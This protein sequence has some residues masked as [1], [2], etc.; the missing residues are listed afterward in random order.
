MI[1]VSPRA[2]PGLHHVFAWAQF[3]SGRFCSRFPSA[4]ALFAGLLLPGDSAASGCFCLITFFQ[5]QGELAFGVMILS[6]C[7]GGITS[8][9]MTR[10]ARGDV[11][12]SISYTAIV[13]L[14]TALTLPLILSIALAPISLWQST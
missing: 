5:L 14:L 4:K 2:Q 8:N 9:V 3:E 7:P 13:S 10:W 12:L 11:A 1:G 6:C